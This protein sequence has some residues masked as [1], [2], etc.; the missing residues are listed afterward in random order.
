M[1]LSTKLWTLIHRV[2]IAR[3]DMTRRFPLGPEG[4]PAGG[5]PPPDRGPDGG[6]IEAP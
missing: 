1:G 3:E 6:S 4:P 5:A 2:A